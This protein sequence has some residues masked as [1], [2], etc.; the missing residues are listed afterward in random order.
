MQMHV[1]KMLFLFYTITKMPPAT[2]G[3]NEEGAQFPGAES[4]W[5][6]QITVGSTIKSQQYHKYFFQYS[7]FAY[8]KTQVRTLGAKLVRGAAKYIMC[9]FCAFK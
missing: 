9:M 6:R 3:H 4:L 5:G 1:H 2:Q 7:T 8:E